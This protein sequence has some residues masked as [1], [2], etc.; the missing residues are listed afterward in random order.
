MVN[1]E[2]TEYINPRQRKMKDLETEKIYTFEIQDDTENIVKQSQT[3]VKA[4]NLNKMQTDLVDDMS[5]TYTGTSIT[6]NTVEGFGRIGKL[7]GNT[8]E[9]GTGDK[10]PDNPYVLECIGDDINLL[11]TIEKVD[12]SLASGVDFY[13][14]TYYLEVESNTDYVLS[15]CKSSSG[16]QLYE[17]D[18]NKSLI[19]QTQYTSQVKFTTSSTTRYIRFR[20]NALANSFPNEEL[21]LQKGPVAT[22]YSPYQKGTVVIKSSNA[23][24]SSTNIIYVDKPL[25]CLKD[26]ED[27]I[28][29]QDYIDYER[30]KIVRQCGYKKFNGS[31]IWSKG[32]MSGWQ[33]KNYLFWT[34]IDDI[35]ESN[36]NTSNQFSLIDINTVVNNT[37][38]NYKFARYT[39]YSSSYNIVFLDKNSD[40]VETFKQKLA[41]N[42]MIL[43]Y[44]L[45]TPVEEDIECSDKIVQY[46]DSTTIQSDAKVE[47]TLTNNKTIAEIY[48][49]IENKNQIIIDNFVASTGT[50]EKLCQY[51][52]G[53]IV[54]VM[55][56]VKFSSSAGQYFELARLKLKPIDAIAIPVPI[57]S[58][59]S[60]DTYSSC[61]VEMGFTGNDGIIMLRTLKAYSNQ[62]ARGYLTY[63]TNDV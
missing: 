25:C 56:N 11:S 15:I 43:V 27:N 20:T 51:R 31:E 28:V 48:E 12:T 36:Y 54:T 44:K 8:T 45:T 62:Y 19:K 10:S 5:K 61:N 14:I 55:F 18:S 39:D 30:R 33:N 13:G 50:T 46:A 23:S 58:H 6:A 4:E 16:F 21:K 32:G 29:A 42:N 1:W 49:N 35:V 2:N 22:E 57:L 17:Y 34:K 7:Y 63:L 37:S 41:K 60:A 9:T 38:A 24:N 53:K 3:P 52:N 47:V 59:I 26:N 40:S